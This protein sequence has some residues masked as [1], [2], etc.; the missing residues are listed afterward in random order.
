MARELHSVAISDLCILAACSLCVEY[1]HV[2]T[3]IV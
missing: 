3:D 1:N 2:S